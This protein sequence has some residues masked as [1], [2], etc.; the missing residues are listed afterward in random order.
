VVGL[1]GTSAGALARID[2]GTAGDSSSSAAGDNEVDEAN[3]S[4]QAVIAD[5]L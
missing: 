3:K 1:N 5:S 2:V 4:D